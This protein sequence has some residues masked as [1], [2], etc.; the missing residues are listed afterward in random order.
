[1]ML[2]GGEM[3]I[4]L[5]F[6]LLGPALQPG[7]AILEL[8]N[9]YIPTAGPLDNILIAT[10]RVDANGQG[11]DLVIRVYN[12][13]QQ[14]ACNPAK[15]GKQCCVAAC[16]A[17]WTKSLV[18]HDCLSVCSATLA[19]GLQSDI[20][21]L[22]WQDDCSLVVAGAL[23][24]DHSTS[25]ML[26]FR[27]GG[28]MEVHMDGILVQKSSRLWAPAKVK[29]TQAFVANSYTERALQQQQ[30]A[31]NNSVITTTTTTTTRPNMLLKSI[32]FTAGAITIPNIQQISPRQPGTFSLTFVDPSIPDPNTA[33]G[34]SPA[35]SASST[36][37]SP[38]STGVSVAYPILCN[39]ASWSLNP[40]GESLLNEDY[41]STDV[42]AFSKSA[43]SGLYLGNFDSNQAHSILAPLQAQMNSLS[44]NVTNDQT[45]ITT[46]DGQIE[47]QQQLCGQLQTALI[48]IV[49]DASTSQ[50]S[51]LQ[52]NPA[53]W[54]QQKD[55][56]SL[57]LRI[58]TQLQSQQHNL[59]TQ[60]A[61][62]NQ[63]LQQV[64]DQFYQTQQQLNLTPTSSNNNISGSNVLCSATGSY[65]IL[66]S[67]YLGGEM[68]LRVKFSVRDSYL[69]S[70]GTVTV[71]KFSNEF[72]QDSVSVSVTGQNTS[73]Y[74][75]QKHSLARSYGVSSQ[76]VT[77]TIQR[78]SI[79][80]T[81]TSASMNTTKCKLHSTQLPRCVCTQS[82][83]QTQSHA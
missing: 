74:W 16:C 25:L 61:A 21:T 82:H 6:T 19:S 47:K 49:G 55:S 14:R 15:P 23:S 42:T 22:P 36:A 48:T 39:G 80:R 78:G 65:A 51:T 24:V 13:G 67:V 41:D 35:I 10:G 40:F 60:Q 73:T 27:V 68:T 81:F 32:S 1:M 3:T 66:G 75:D 38:L 71:M 64:S 50:S 30:R 59:I 63:R 70:N 83:V 77:L 52:A 2:V 44:Q 17:V 28:Y 12:N 33:D 79:S 56:L 72:Q 76:T 29:R 20:S 31:P 53:L 45:L 57:C 11:A 8:G 43:T 4:Q 5:Q 62:Q 34:Q 26:V 18:I 54:A 9:T 7:Q 58:V 69:F 37:G 46:L